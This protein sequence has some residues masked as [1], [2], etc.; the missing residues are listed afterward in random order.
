MDHPEAPHVAVASRVAA[1]FAPLQDVR[2]V[3]LGGSRGAGGVSWDAGSDIDLEVYTRRDLPLEVRERI[4]RA[5]GAPE[6]LGIGRAYWGTADEWLDP[7]TG[8]VVDATY[9]D[10]AW[11]EDQLDR[12]LVRHEPGLGYSTCFWHTIRGAVPLHDPDGWLAG[13][14]ATADVP[15]PDRLRRNV[16]G[17]NLG[18]L[19]G[20]PSAW[21]VQV[22]KAAGRGDAVAVNHR[23]AGLLASYFDVLFALN[24]VPHP[25]EKRLIEA[26]ERSCPRRPDGMRSGLESLLA[27][28]AAG[29]ERMPGLVARLLD[30]LEAVVDADPDLDL[31]R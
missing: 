14:K 3:A 2:A 16:I 1:L 18:A 12:V 20:F 4:A 8:L 19:R 9:F 6:P 29:L 17:H 31:G 26:A 23:L 22:A 5:A 15:Y 24:R 25:G 30:A 13:L 27:S 11:M 21:E 7:A 28:S 10:A